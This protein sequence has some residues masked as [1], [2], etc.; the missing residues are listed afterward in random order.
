MALRS[1]G[2]EPRIRAKLNAKFT[3]SAQKFIYRYTTRR[4]DADDAE[5]VVFLNYGYE[6]DPPMSVPLAE[7]DEPNRYAIQLYHSTATQADLRGKR[8]LEV[9]CGHGGG[10]AYLAR[11]LQPSSYTGLDVNPVGIEYCRKTHD[12]AGLDFVQGDAEDLPFGDQSFDAVLNVESSHL[13]PRFPRFLEEVAR[14]LAP[15]GH[16]LYTDARAAHAIAGWEAALAAAPLRLCTQRVIN[17]EVRRGMATTLQQWQNVIDRVTPR[18]LRRV[19]R[20]F[21]PAQRAYDDLGSDGS[22]EYR[23]YSFVK[24]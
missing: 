13:Y 24:E 19:V 7:V 10:A 17:T 11:A 3:Q 12:V 8:V 20:D 4:L 2:R 5:E 15:G 23:M 18:P 16:F 6:E 21:A 1:P 9:G 14:V 22:S